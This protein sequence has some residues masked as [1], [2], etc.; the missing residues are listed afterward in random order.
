MGGGKGG[1]PH[2]AIAFIGHYIDRYVAQYPDNPDAIKIQRT[3]SEG[4]YRP[5]SADVPLSTVAG[6]ILEKLER[7]HYVAMAGGYRDEKGAGHALFF[8]FIL[9]EEDGLVK[10][11]VTNTGDGLNFHPRQN[12]DTQRENIYR[13]LVFSGAKIEDLRKSQFLESLVS[14]TRE[15]ADLQHLSGIL[16]SMQPKK[17]AV[18]DLYDVFFHAWPGDGPFVAKNPG[19]AQRANSCSLQAVVKW[20]N[21]VCEEHHHPFLMIWIKLAGFSDYLDNA[22]AHSSQFVADALR[23]MTTHIDKMDKCGELSEGLFLAWKEI[24]QRALEVKGRAVI[25]EVKEREK[26]A[27]SVGERGFELDL[28]ERLDL[29]FHGASGDEL[30]LKKLHKYQRQHG[31]PGDAPRLVD[32]SELAQPY[33]APLYDEMAGRLNFFRLLPDCI[34]SGGLFEGPDKQNLLTD[35]GVLFQLFFYPPKA[36]SFHLPD[37]FVVDLLNGWMILYLEAR[38]EETIP[39]DVF[40][41]WLEGVSLLQEKYAYE[42]SFDSPNSQRRWFLIQVLVEKETKALLDKL[43]PNYRAPPNYW[44][45]YDQDFN[46]RH[47]KWMPFGIEFKRQRPERQGGWGSSGTAPIEDKKELPAMALFSRTVMQELASRPKPQKKME[48]CSPEERL[49]FQAST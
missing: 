34:S 39:P 32:I 8:E 41:E 36:G 21:N 17:M 23:K 28:Y 6:E 22:D 37:S 25:R 18:S 9:D 14:F 40:L 12:E 48:E 24:S 27:L 3:L 7:E 10:F 31:F 35:L 30:A 42:Y 20:M 44:T 33:V 49:I 46:A 38:K 13:T 1:D 26:L 47:F 45:I 29:T 19:G 4:V 11:Q 43:G 16:E 5:P 15:R 2:Q